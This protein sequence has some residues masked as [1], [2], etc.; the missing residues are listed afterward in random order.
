MSGSASDYQCFD[1]TKGTSIHCFSIDTIYTMYITLWFA[2]PEDL[3]YLAFKFVALR[4]PRVNVILET[5]RAQ[6]CGF[7]TT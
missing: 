1:K 2:Y 6:F 3:I 4:L 7:E 5:R